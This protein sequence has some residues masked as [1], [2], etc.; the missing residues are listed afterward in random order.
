MTPPR[1]SRAA[2]D[3]ALSVLRA[4]E[5]ELLSLARC[6]QDAAASHPWLPDAPRRQRLAQ[7]DAARAA[8]LA[9][10]IAWME[11]IE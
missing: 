2:I 11:G 7:R 10:A 5:R 8:R 3:A 9:E 4:K 6:R 1:P